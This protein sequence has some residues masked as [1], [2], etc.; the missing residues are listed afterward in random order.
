MQHSLT[1]YSVGLEVV[2]DVTFLNS[3]LVL[4]RFLVI[5]S[6][7]LTI[8]VRVV[9]AGVVVFGVKR[10]V[11]KVLTISKISLH[12]MGTFINVVHIY[13]FNFRDQSSVPCVTCN[14]CY[15]S[16]NIVLCGELFIQADGKIAVDIFL[17]VGNCW[18]L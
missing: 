12:S 5:N 11:I 14:G 18:G 17:I 9:V 3:T 2:I 8:F 6:Y 4:L 15:A 13:D 16:H 7:D 10:D 1:S